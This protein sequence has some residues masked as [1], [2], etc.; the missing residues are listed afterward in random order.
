MDQEYHSLLF[1]RDVPGSQAARGGYEIS[2][3]GT[4]LM[5]IL[6]ITP[7]SFSDGGR[8]ADADRALR[9]AQAMVGSG[10]LIVDVGGESTRP[11]ARP[12]S[13]AEELKRVLPVVERL[14]A[15]TKALIS[16]DTSK[17]QVARE[18]LLMG[19]HL[20]NDVT[21][22]TDPNMVE[23][24]AEAGVPAVVMHMQGNPRSMQQNPQYEDVV[25]EVESFLLTQ[26]ESALANGL[27]SVLIDPGLGFGKTFEHNLA[28]LRSLRKMSSFGYPVLV[29]GS[30][31]RMIE[32]WA[33]RSEPSSRDPGSIALHLFAISQGAAMVRIHDVAGH[34]QAL[35]V[36]KALHG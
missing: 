27:P 35:L 30:R 18:A 9:C 14:A 10:A 7:D 29:G 21:G 16:I 6:N 33:G 15:E 19:A 5:G 2:W 36:W 4:A 11:G 24:C 1:Y 22:L 32:Q 31:K 13:E 20:V 28:L 23:V 34:A 26:A 8:I 3:S 12:V 25:L 17:P